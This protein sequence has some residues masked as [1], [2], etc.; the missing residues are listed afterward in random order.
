MRIALVVPGGVDRSGEYRVIPVLLALISRLARQNDVHVYALNQEIEESAW[1]LG[2]ATI[3]NFGPRRSRVRAIRAICTAHRESR[4]DLIQAIWSGACGMVAVAA[5]RLL[6]IP[7]AVHIAGGELVA[8]KD[9]GYGGRLTWKGRVRE[10]LVLRGASAITA[11]SAPILASLSELGLRAERLPLGIDLKSWPARQPV[12][13]RDVR[14]AKLIHVA[15]LNRVKDQ[16]TLLNALASLMASGLSFEMEVVGEDTLGGEIQSL[17]ARLGLSDAVRFQG[18]LTQRQLRPLLETADLLIM[19]SR[20]EAGPVV[21]LEAAAVG[22][23]TVGTAVGHIAEWA[24]YA[25]TAVPV[26]DCA[27]LAAAIRDLL[28]DEDKRLRIASEALNRSVG[29]DADNTAQRFQALYA[30]LTAIK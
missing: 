20:H 14:P 3:H 7:S 6:G 24:P 23:P 4:F 1:S 18:F 12:R 2:G 17:S 28:T 19:S 10:A 21:M 5:A 27:G 30:R 8:V 9:I 11:A 22:V 15:S 13:R 16:P 29:E 25:A 26:G